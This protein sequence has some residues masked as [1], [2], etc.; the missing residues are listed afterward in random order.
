[1]DMATA[2]S[3][4]AWHHSDHLPL[5]REVMARLREHPILAVNPALQRDAARHGM[6]SLLQ[7]LEWMLYH[8][9]HSLHEYANVDTLERRVQALV[10]HYKRGNSS[11]GA[12]DLSD[13]S[14][15]SE[16]HADEATSESDTDVKAPR[17]RRLRSVNSE[18]DALPSGK[19]QHTLP[20]APGSDRQPECH[21]KVTVGADLQQRHGCSLSHNLDLLRHT[22]SFLD[23]REALKCRAVSQFFRLHAPS[24]VCT[25]HVDVST[26]SGS[27]LRPSQDAHGLAKLL[28]QCQNLRAVSISSSANL[29]NIKAGVVFP[30][31]LSQAS[32]DTP[33]SFG[34]QV[35]LALAE[36]VARGGCRKL[37]AL[38]LHA[39]FDFANESTAALELL[40]SLVT[41]DSGTAPSTDRPRV[42]KRSAMKRI[43]LDSTFLGD[44]GTMELS[45]MVEDNP[46]VF[47]RVEQF[48]LRNNFFGEGG[49]Q[50]VIEAIRVSMPRLR[51]LDLSQNILTDVDAIRIADL[52]D[53]PASVGGLTEAKDQTEAE[54]AMH[55]LLAVPRLRSVQLEGNFIGCEG[56]HAISIA[57]CARRELVRQA[58]REDDSQSED[59]DGVESFMLSL[60]DS[61]LMDEEEEETE[62]VGSSA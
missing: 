11:S 1:M 5:R 14:E 59:Y 4:P 33:A 61:D 37:E 46:H 3:A 29:S 47:R 6:P 53:Q 12:A 8:A 57:L 17:T 55:S 36:A 9:A 2:G 62:E 10:T 27:G 42:M 56:Y 23:G 39:P 21:I 38:E 15:D 28:L 13:T 54:A 41:A 60:E 49:C 45:R 52:L 34:H 25:L 40:R 26:L 43:V 35:A 22:F 18:N 44:K 30:R 20:S 58:S 50:A 51:T 32:D 16:A 24:F 7:R 48:G 19:R 31:A